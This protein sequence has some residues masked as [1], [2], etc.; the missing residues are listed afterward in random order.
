[1]KN[2]I[3]IP[4]IFLVGVFT[5]LFAQ[6]FKV[7][8]NKLTEETQQLSESPD[9][10]RLIWWIPTEFWQTIFEQDNTITKLEANEML[11]NFDKYTMVAVIDG[12]IKDDG[13][14]TY[15][16][17]ET[18]FKNLAVIGNDKVAYTPLYDDEIDEV[19]RNLINIMK[20]MLGNMLGAFG[21]NMHFYLFQKRD[22]PLD[23]IVNPIKKER[24]T[25]KLDKDNFNWSLPLGSLLKPKKCPVDY[26][27]HNGSWN[28]CPYHGKK[29]ELN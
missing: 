3:L 1:M 17:E 8:I 4:L 7:N 12:E 15:K 23:R 20:P 9:T 29:L 6:G 14:I 10:M 25:V 22:N 26:K 28:Y 2:K 16:T 24:F 13:T 11:N 21:Q 18:T 27:L 19:T 5:N